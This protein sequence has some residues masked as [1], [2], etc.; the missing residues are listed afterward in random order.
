MR[1]AGVGAR[2]RQSQ[3]FASVCGGEAVGGHDDA[4]GSGAVA[5]VESGGGGGGAGW[6]DEVDAVGIVTGDPG[7]ASSVGGDVA[8][9]GGDGDFEGGVGVEMAAVDGVVVGVCGPEQAA[10]GVAGDGAGGGGRGIC[11][12]RRGDGDADDAGGDG[13]RRGAGCEDFAD[14]GFGAVVAGVGV[15]EGGGG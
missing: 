12:V 2:T 4:V 1:A 3:N 9:I 8:G 10:D 13:A 11:G 6:G 7:A 14:L 5:K 15:G